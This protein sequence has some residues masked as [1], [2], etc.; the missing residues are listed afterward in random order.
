[1]IQSIGMVGVVDGLYNYRCSSGSLGNSSTA[2]GNSDS[3]GT[4]GPSYSSAVGNDFFRAYCMYFI[5]YSLLPFVPSSSASYF[6]LAVPMS[7]CS[8]KHS[9]MSVTFNIAILNGEIDL[10]PKLRLS[11][12]KL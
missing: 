7:K 4:A 3:G 11:K 2:S 12:S 5:P 10:G 9:Y 6:I 1:M 8:R